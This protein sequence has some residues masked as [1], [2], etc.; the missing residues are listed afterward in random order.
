MFRKLSNDDPGRL[1]V[2][3]TQKVIGR[4]TQIRYF[5]LDGF[6]IY[7]RAILSYERCSFDPTKSLSLL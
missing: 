7:G 5:L 2:P 1:E 3:S 6:G 4:L